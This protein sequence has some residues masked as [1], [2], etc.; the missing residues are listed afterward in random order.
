MSLWSYC[1]SVC[2]GKASLQSRATTAVLRCMTDRQFQVSERNHLYLNPSRLFRPCG[3][4]TFKCDAEV[5]GWKGG[6]GQ[7]FASVISW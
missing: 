6:A 1:R 7:Q 5:G 2:S 3:V 4:L